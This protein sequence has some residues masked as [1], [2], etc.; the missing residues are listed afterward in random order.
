[1]KNVQKEITSIDGLLRSFDYEYKYE[2]NDYTPSGYFARLERAFPD[3]IIKGGSGFEGVYGGRSR[4]NTIRR[5]RMTVLNE[6]PLDDSVASLVFKD[7]NAVI[8]YDTSTFNRER[9]GKSTSNKNFDL[10]N[11]Q[12]NFNH[13]KTIYAWIKPIETIKGAQRVF[14]LAE[15]KLLKL[16]LL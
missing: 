2:Y 14:A 9:K 10:K 5:K 6:N 1:M 4:L 15:K 3:E 12:D 11:W 7:D 16:D 8:A 13:R